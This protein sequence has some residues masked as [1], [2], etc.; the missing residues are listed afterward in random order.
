[1]FDWFDFDKQILTRFNYLLI[2]QL[3]PLLVISSFLVNEI[4]PTLFKKQMIYY[5]LG[6]LIFFVAIIIPW[7]RILWW[8]VPFVYISSLILVEMVQFFGITIDGAKRWIAIPGI[9]FTVQPSELMKISVILMLAYIIHKNPPPAEGYGVKVFLKLSVIILIPFVLILKQ[10]DLGTALSLLLVAYGVLFI[11]GIKWKIWLSLALIVGL[12]APILYT[13]GLKPYQ[14]QRIHDFVNEPSY[15]VKQALIAIG[16]GG[17][18]GKSKDE[19][20]QTQMKFLPVVS[21]DFIFAYLGERLGFVGMMSVVALYIL[22]ILHLLY[23]SMKETKDYLIKVFA[24]GLAWIFFI[25]M[26]VNIYMIIGLAPV[27][28]LPLPMFS[29]GGTS[30]MIFIALFGILQNLLAFKNYLGY[31][32]DSKITMISR[33]NISAR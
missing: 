11:I 21:S 7:R 3:L 19:A 17:L 32:T 12:S 4:S 16:S 2:L 13:Y 27:V 31:N 5:I 33:E 14:K 26:V 28:G 22:L 15:Q 1:M 6:F 24:T 18:H 8:F 9:G 20:T 29:H 25:H 30:F 23:I 10:P